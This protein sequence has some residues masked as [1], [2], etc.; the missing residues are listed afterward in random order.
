MCVTD[1]V[2]KWSCHA[3]SNLQS[4]V[5]EYSNASFIKQYVSYWTRQKLRELGRRS[6]INYKENNV[7]ITEIFWV[8][9]T[10]RFI[11]AQC[12]LLL[13]FFVKYNTDNSWQVSWENTQTVIKCLPS[14]GAHCSS[15][16]PLCSD[17]FCPSFAPPADSSCGSDCCLFSGE[18]KGL[19]GRFARS[20]KHESK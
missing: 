15:P 2:Q 8:K 20:L 9:K 18:H 11:Y 10:G 12:I 5:V 3:T 14:F 4:K 1:H 6:R 19:L 7:A 16:P 17:P 13:I